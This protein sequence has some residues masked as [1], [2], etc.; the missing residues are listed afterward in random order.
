MLKYYDQ[1]DELTLQCDASETGL[2]TALTQR[3]KPVAFGSRALTPTER[4]YAQIEKECLAIVFGRE[5]FHQYTCGR[6]LTFQSDHKPLKN[7]HRKPLHSA[8][9]RLQ[10]MLLRLQKYDLSVN[11]VPGRD[12]LLADTQS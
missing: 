9:K 2:G 1:E 3:G 11:Y 4:G 7:I 10:R 5:R 8:P 12:M 6:K